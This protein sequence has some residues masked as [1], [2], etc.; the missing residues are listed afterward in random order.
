MVRCV[1]YRCS[2]G[3]LE[4]VAV[5]NGAM[6]GVKTKGGPRLVTFIQI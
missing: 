5:N 6:L 4:R 3:M 2:V 1:G